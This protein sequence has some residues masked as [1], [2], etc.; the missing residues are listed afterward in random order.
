R[1]PQKLVF[2]ELGNLFTGDNNADGGDRARWVHVIEGADSGYRYGY[3]WMNAPH[4]R[5]PW[6]EEKL[7]HPHFAGQA[8]YIVPPVAWPG[9]LGRTARSGSAPGRRRP[10][11]LLSLQL[12]RRADL[13]P[14]ARVHGET[15]RR[16]V[17]ARAG[18]DV[19]RGLL[20]DRRRGRPRRRA[21]LDRLGLGLGRHG[22]GPDLSRDARD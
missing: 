12:R 4:L 1:N 15:E 5:G 14:G 19:P 3:Q 21:L 20:A 2:D 17:R 11:P 7:W 8:A 13:E 10:R 9:S 16:V 18:H 22:Q 6:N